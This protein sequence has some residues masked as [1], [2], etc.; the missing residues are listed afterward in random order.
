MF[1]SAFPDLLPVLQAC[2]VDLLQIRDILPLT[3][4]VEVT[5]P[6]LVHDDTVISELAMTVLQRLEAHTLFIGMG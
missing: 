3:P 1:L 4:L 2:L 6:L 5:V